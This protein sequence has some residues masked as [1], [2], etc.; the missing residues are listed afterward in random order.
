MNIL[1]INAAE[2]PPDWVLPPDAD[3]AL[4]VGD[5]VHQV[6]PRLAPGSL[7][8]LITDPPYSSGGMFRGDRAKPTSAKYLQDEKTN[9]AGLLP[10]FYGD[11]RDALAHLW[12]M[13]VWLSIGWAACKPGA[14]IAV[15]ADWRQVAA[16]GIAVQV[17]GFTQRGIRP[18]VKPAGSYRMQ[19]HL[20]GNDSEFCV[21]GTR[22]PVMPWEGCEAAPN[23]PW[24]A[25]APRGAE[26][27]HQTEKPL[28]IMRDLV[29]TVPPGGVI[30]D[31]FA[32]SGTT[33]EAALIE[34][35]RVIGCELSEDYADRIMMRLT[36]V[37]PVTEPGS[38]QEPLFGGKP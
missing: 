29:R 24:M 21:W 19:W 18:W 23:S 27:R 22:G 6:L 14:F 36:T 28:Q 30:L 10:D 9:V 37:D 38:T 33:M 35:R 16:A 31:P 1:R 8:G 11:N 2:L 4:I 32:G 7:D 26:K 15:F 17:A 20:P 25:R 5:A 12:W 34:G 13:Q 3:A